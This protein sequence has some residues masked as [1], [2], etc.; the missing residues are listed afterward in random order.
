MSQEQE[1]K[2]VEES[3][4]E[5]PTASTPPSTPVENTDKIVKKIRKKRTHRWTE[6]NKKSFYEKCV[7]ARLASLAKKKSLKLKE[8]AVSS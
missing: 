3:Q 7:P 1:I 4:L 5:L 6:A 2:T 8:V